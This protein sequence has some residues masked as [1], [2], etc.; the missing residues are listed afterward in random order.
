MWRMRFGTGMPGFLPRVNWPTQH[1]GATKTG[2]QAEWHDVRL[3]GEGHLLHAH[4]ILTAASISVWKTETAVC[5][6][7][8]K[9]PFFGFLGVPPLVVCVWPWKPF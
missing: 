6:V 9:R 1:R 4:A 5:R 3:F 2:A 7:Q 8:Q